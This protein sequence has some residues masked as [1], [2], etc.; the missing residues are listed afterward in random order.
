MPPQLR[1]RHWVC[2]LPVIGRGTHT[3]ESNDKD[4]SDK[5][6][7]CN[8]RTYIETSRCMS[9]GSKNIASLGKLFVMLKIV[10]PAAEPH[11][12]RH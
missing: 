2:K 10:R 9:S 8:L 6:A 12:F 5:L 4:S 1:K 11:T 3:A 7:V